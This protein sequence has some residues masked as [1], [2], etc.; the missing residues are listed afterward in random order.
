MTRF[1]LAFAAFLSASAFAAP[2]ATPSREAPAQARTSAA[3]RAPGL[4]STLE[5]ALPAPAQ[6]RAE[7]PTTAG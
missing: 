7:P 5:V 6:K 1:L 2:A 3:F 4:P